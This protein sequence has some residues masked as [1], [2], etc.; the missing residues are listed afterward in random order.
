MCKHSLILPTN[1]SFKNLFTPFD[2]KICFHQFQ[3]LPRCRERRQVGTTNRW[4]LPEALYSDL[5]GNSQAL[6]AIN[7][8]YNSTLIRIIT[9]TNPKPPTPPPLESWI[10][11]KVHVPPILPDPDKGDYTHTISQ[12][13]RAYS[14]GA[15][16]RS[17]RKSHLMKEKC[18]VDSDLPDQNEE[19]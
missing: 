11:P 9:G 19:V 10:L 15:W 16:R 5:L 18:Q 2:L 7:M 8:P 6:K 12:A 4:R 17:S 14:S 1:F 3:V 13:A